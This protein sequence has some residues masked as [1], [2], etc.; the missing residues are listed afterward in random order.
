M[1]LIADMKKCLSLFSSHLSIGIAEDELYG[2]EEITLSR[3]IA[4][5]N[6]VVLWR[7]RFG[8]GLILIAA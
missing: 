1:E 2:L 3:A 4:P 8:N 5:N 7:E 6:D